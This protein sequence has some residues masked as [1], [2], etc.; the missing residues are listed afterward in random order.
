MIELLGNDSC[1]YDARSMSVADLR[2]DLQTASRI[3]DSERIARAQFFLWW[4]AGDGAAFSRLEWATLSDP[5]STGWAARAAATKSMMVGDYSAAAEHDRRAIAIA[6][7]RNDRELEAL[8][9]EKLSVSLGYLGDLPASIQALAQ[10]RTIGVIDPVAPHGMMALLNDCEDAANHADIEAQMSAANIALT[11]ATESASVQASAMCAT[12]VA[13]VLL[14]SGD[15]QQARSLAYASLTSLPEVCTNNFDAARLGIAISVMI[16]CGDMHVAEQ[17]LPLAQHVAECFGFL[18]FQQEIDLM[19]ARV[20]ASLG[21]T[22]ML[23]EMLRDTKIVE[24][25]LASR[26]LLVSARLATQLGSSK[27]METVSNS[28]LQSS[29]EKCRLGAYALQEIDGHVARD[30]QKL[31]EA[32][33]NWLSHSQVFHGAAALAAAEFVDITCTA[34]KS[35]HHVSLLA[36]VLRNDGDPG[37]ALERIRDANELRARPYSSGMFSFTARQWQIVSRRACG[38]SQQSIAI[39][40]GLRPDS[41]SRTVNALKRSQIIAQHG[42]W[43]PFMS[44]HVIPSLTVVDVA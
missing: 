13:N 3:G 2:Q 29:A 35:A 4:K 10:A 40:L 41:V 32:A 21:N 38:H 8:S 26:V 11:I 39:E 12:Y 15:E 30:C 28:E 16:D 36:Q 24:P 27:L 44:L 25:G 5:L 42:G 23:C 34:V 1:K 43:A 33:A 22:T 37:I 18:S 7:T 20:S 31:R 17:L 6:R 9:L 14:L 19:Q